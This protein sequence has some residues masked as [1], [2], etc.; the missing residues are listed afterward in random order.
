[1]MKANSKIQLGNTAM[2]L[3]CSKRNPGHSVMSSKD[4]HFSAVEKQVLALG[5]RSLR[6][7]SSSIECL[8]GEEYTK[9]LDVFS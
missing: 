7:R 3:P 5:W 2:S 6:N 8:G 1:M 9:G 4:K